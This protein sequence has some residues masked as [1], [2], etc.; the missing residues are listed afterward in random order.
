MSKTQNK[1][2]K[3]ITPKGPLQ[4]I[5]I[6]GWGKLKMEREENSKNRDD[7]EYTASIVLPAADAAPLIAAAKELYNERKDKT[8]KFKSW[9]FRPCLPNGRVK[10]EE[11]VPLDV[12]EE[13][14]THF[15][16]AFRTG[17]DYP[18]KGDEKP[19]PKTIGV[20]NSKG[21][22][23]TARMSDTRIG[24]GSLGQLGGAMNYGSY[25]G[26]DFISWYLD[27]V[28]VSKFEAFNAD[29]GFEA[30]EADEDGW[31]GP[32]DDDGDG[33]AGDDGSGSVGG[34]TDSAVASPKLG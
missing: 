13:D 22:N 18:K 2:V 33:I 29:S 16:F 25:G 7:Y 14:A 19:K 3:L 32:E 6:T 28:K 26:S 27:N 31:T 34:G 9:G 17:L 8:Q 5:Y 12:K 4:W 20:F 10:D 21:E 11:G 24:H 23:I 15:L 1:P 30:D